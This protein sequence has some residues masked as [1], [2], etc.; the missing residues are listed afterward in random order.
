MAEHESPKQTKFVPISDSGV[1]TIF[2]LAL[3]SPNTNTERSFRSELQ[4][5]RAAVSDR[6][7]FMHEQ[8]IEVGNDWLCT[9]RSALLPHALHLELRYFEIPLT[10]TAP[11]KNMSLTICQAED[12]LDSKLLI[13]RSTRSVYSVV[14][15]VFKA[16]IQSTE[17]ISAVDAHFGGVSPE[18][19]RGPSLW[20]RAKGESKATIEDQLGIETVN[21]D[22]RIL[23]AVTLNSWPVS[24]RNDF[25]VAL[26]KLA[27][28]A[29]LV[30][31]V[32]SSSAAEQTLRLV[33]IEGF[34]SAQIMSDQKPKPARSLT[35]TPSDSV[36]TG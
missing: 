32:D 18:I 6:G 35:R 31:L 16:D 3:T 9:F 21:P 15:E 33:A 5:L 12:S 20:S 24:D 27:A 2:S 11:L 13:G 4:D 30:N 29:N 28:I 34:N 36:E 26:D 25:A 22:R 10:D 7:F 8:G 23:N 17:K 1:A 14:E 19:E